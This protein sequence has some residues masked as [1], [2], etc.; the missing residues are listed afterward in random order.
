[1]SNSSGGVGG[2]PSSSGRT[3]IPEPLVTPTSSGQ[4]EVPL[5]CPSRT[6]CN[7]F[8]PLCDRLVHSVEVGTMWSDRGNRGTSHRDRSRDR[9]PSSCSYS[10]GLYDTWVTTLGSNKVTT[11][12][13][14]F[15][16]FRSCVGFSGVG[17]S[18]VRLQDPWREVGPGR[19]TG[20]LEDTTT[21]TTW[22]MSSSPSEE[23]VR[24]SKKLLTPE[25]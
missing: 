19:I 13:Y 12:T 5:S 2:F 25:K 6:P 11:Y 10:L 20:D 4:S 18:L 3:D 24:D 7:N 14:R 8:L 23:G 17:T 21:E 15:G 22:T 1:M 9:H 16:A